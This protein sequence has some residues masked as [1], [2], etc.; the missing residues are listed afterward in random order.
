MPE[1]RR[2][3]EERDALVLRWQYLPRW[4]VSRMW[5][6]PHV[7]RY[8]FDDSVQT[9]FLALVRAAEKW[10]EAE[11]VQFS[12]YAGRAMYNELLREARQHGGTIY[13]P[14]WAHSPD[15]SAHPDARRA[16]NVRN[17]PDVQ[18]P[19]REAGTLD[20]LVEAIDR[21]ACLS[22]AFAHATPEDRRLLRLRYLDEL[23]L[24][25][26]GGTLGVTRERVRQKVIAAVLRARNALS[27][28][29]PR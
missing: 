26:I 11:G 25:E 28:D 17:S 12:T 23:T 13:V 29:L 9:C 8:G 27:R 6:I 2:S 22:T 19:D 16:W 14:L 1:A 21:Q 10:D 24:K 4:A 18:P 5:K 15:S 20:E 3:R 7:R